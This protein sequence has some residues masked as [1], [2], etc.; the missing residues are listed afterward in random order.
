MSYK[1]KYGPIIHMGISRTVSH[2]NSYK[3][4][5]HMR[6]SPYINACF[7]F[8]TMS[9]RVH[10]SSKKSGGNDRDFIMQ[11]TEEC[12]FVINNLLIITR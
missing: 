7:E 8:F 4:P 12:T 10:K 5:L 11:S 3:R 9:R 2:I 1:T 6:T